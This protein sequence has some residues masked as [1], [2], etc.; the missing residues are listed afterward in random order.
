MMM[1]MYNSNT[2]LIGLTWYVT[3]Y[4]RYHYM[5]EW[6]VN[7]PDNVFSAFLYLVVGLD[8]ISYYPVKSNLNVNTV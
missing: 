4:I 6:N 2:G 7:T 8:T 5:H 3:L 1:T